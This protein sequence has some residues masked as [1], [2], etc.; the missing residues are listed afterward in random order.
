MDT[1][2]VYTQ[3]HLCRR[4]LVGVMVGSNMAAVHDENPPNKK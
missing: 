3:S 2:T 1:F 4:G